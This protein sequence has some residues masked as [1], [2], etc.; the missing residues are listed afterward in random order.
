M[1]Y[2]QARAK[3]IFLNA[4]E[5]ACERARLAYIQAQCGGDDELRRDVAGLLD[6]AQRLGR[7]LE[8]SPQ[9]HQPTIDEPIR[10]RPGAQIGHYTLLEEIGEGGMGVVYLAEQEE[11]VERQGA[12]KIVRPGMDTRNVV[13]RFEGEMLTFR[14]SL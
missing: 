14:R 9:D 7:F 6:H 8:S 4:M 2:V 3:N 10:E 11:P 12:L 1:P 13:A 5:I